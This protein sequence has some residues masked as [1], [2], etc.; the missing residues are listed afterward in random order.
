MKKTIMIADESVENCQALSDILADEFTILTAGNIDEAVELF[1][2][3]QDD[4]A[5]VIIHVD[6]LQQEQNP[7]IWKQRTTD[8]WKCMPVLAIVRSE[9]AEKYTNYLDNGIHDFLY[10]PFID[11]LIRNRVKNL[12]E[13]YFRN[14]DLEEKVRIQTEQLRSQYTL[15]QG[16]AKE[17]KKSNQNIIDILGTVVECRNLESSEHIRHIKAYTGIL[18]RQI[19]EDYPEYGLTESKIEVIVNASALHDIG[20][21]TIPDEILL[22]PG[23]LTDDE[24]DYMKSHTSRGCEILDNIKDAWGKDYDKYCH[25][26]CKYHHERFD[27]RGYPEGLTGDNIPIAAQLVSLADVY[28]ALVGERC[29]KEAYSKDVA[30]EMILQGKCGIF[31]PKILEALIKTREKMEAVRSD[32]GEEYDTTC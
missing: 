8:K 9:D 24:Y 6:M 1:E 15:M 13:A 28:D 3:N 7:E 11:K 27:G 14:S 30:Y 5:L 21:I 23:K 29:Y 26:I 10:I 20:K 2:N 32:E 19:R 18:A 4:L 31:S 22:K 17:L 25:E 12:S 16:Q